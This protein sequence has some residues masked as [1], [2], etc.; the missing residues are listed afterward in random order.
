MSRLTRKASK[1]E[2]IDSKYL[3]SYVDNSKNPNP[4]QNPI[5]LSNAYDKL[6]KLE[7]LEEQLG[8]PLDLVLI[9]YFISGLKKVWYHNQWCD[10]VRVVA[11]EE[12]T[13][14]YMEVR[15]KDYD[16]LKFIPLT[17]YKKTFWLKEDKSE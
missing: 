7:D 15:C 2:L 6:G 14:P 1:Q 5:R 10:V 16:Y 9:P 17:N 4:A 3:F 11:Y 12:A 13:T 8:C